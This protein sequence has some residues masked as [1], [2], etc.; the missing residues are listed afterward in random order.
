MGVTAVP[1]RLIT[2]AGAAPS[3]AARA[4]VNFNGV[5][6]VAIRASANVSSVTDN[7]T[8]DYTVNF[9]VPMGS[10]DLAFSLHS[11]HEINADNFPRNLQIVANS[12]ESIRVKSV[13]QSAVG[14]DS[15]SLNVVIFQ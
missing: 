8:G 7:G 12:A 10:V 1:E 6:V 3:Y 9:A 2:A 5:G 11:D 15:Q 4:W 14:E 13:N